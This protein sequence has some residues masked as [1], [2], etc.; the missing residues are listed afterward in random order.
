L[1]CKITAS[2][3]LVLA[4]QF[5]TAAILVNGQTERGYEVCYKEFRGIMGVVLEIPVGWQ[6]LT[7]KSDAPLSYEFLRITSP[8]RSFAMGLSFYPELRY[9]SAQEW[10]ISFKEYLLRTSP[11]YE[12]ISEKDRKIGNHS[13]Y[14]LTLG[15]ENQRAITVHIKED[16]HFWVFLAVCDTAK[17]YTYR[18]VLE[19]CVST[20]R[21]AFKIT[22]E[23]TAKTPVKIDGKETAPGTL[24]LS[25]FRRYEFEASDTVQTEDSIH[26]FQ[27]WQI[28]EKTENTRKIEIYT[29]KSLSLKVSYKSRF[30]LVA[31]SEYG[32]VEGSGWYDEGSFAKVSL[33]LTRVG[34]PLTGFRFTH[35]S[36]D[37]SG[38]DQT[39]TIR[40]NGPKVVKAVWTEDY[41]AV[42][43]IIVV[44]GLAIGGFLVYRS[45][46]RKKTAPPP[47]SEI[48]PSFSLQV[49]MQS[50][51]QLPETKPVEEQKP[52][53]K[54]VEAPLPEPV[55]GAEPK[56]GVTMSRHCIAEG[57]EPKKFCIHCGAEIAEATGFCANCGR[58]QE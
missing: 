8:D 34:G 21:P 3:L 56:E 5:A 15:K 55:T 45:N 10:G 50:K 20:F 58:L 49:E 43:T 47:P 27:K 52:I 46:K 57:I 17:E 40:M 28:D 7:T 11:E 30:R 1:K 37:A 32:N 36:G 4:A 18:P 12:V 35:W 44:L 13:V 16:S 48:T 2:I 19:R 51:P 41:T 42:Y 54:T 9:D 26:V 29:S 25:P 23:S 22:L 6:Q 33:S 14:E 39:V 24:Y 31:L 38:S 53:P